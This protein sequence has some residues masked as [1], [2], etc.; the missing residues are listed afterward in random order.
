[1]LAFVEVDVGMIGGSVAFAGVLS[2]HYVLGLLAGF[3]VGKF[4]HKSKTGRPRG[5]L[6]HLCYRLFPPFVVP[7][8]AT[9]PSF[10]EDMYG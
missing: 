5:G 10:H 6:K 7:L 8:R 2:G 3:M 9:P 1:M 4:Y